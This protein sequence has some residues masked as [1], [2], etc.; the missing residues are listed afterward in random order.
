VRGSWAVHFGEGVDIGIL[1]RRLTLAFWRGGR[2]CTLEQE[3]RLG[4]GS[5]GTRR[6]EVRQ[7]DLRPDLRRI[8]GNDFGSGKPLN[9]GCG[10][11]GTLA[12]VVR[13]VISLVNFLYPGTLRELK[14]NDSRTGN[15]CVTGCD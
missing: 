10:A 2:H 8:G 6:S 4:S 12:V 7:H 1:A 9:G 15:P 3:G 14:G 5:T 11:G 13:S